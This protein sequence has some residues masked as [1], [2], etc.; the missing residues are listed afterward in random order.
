MAS[1]YYKKFHE[2]CIS[3]LG[4]KCVL[5]SSL[6][7]LQIDH[8]NPLSKSFDL[9]Q[10]WTSYGSL[11]FEEELVK[12]QVLCKPCHQVK[13]G[14]EASLR[15]KKDRNECHGSLSQY[16]R[17]GCRCDKCKLC[18]KVWKRSRSG[19]TVWKERA[20]TALCG[21]D[22]RYT[23]HGCRCDLCRRAH[24]QAAKDYRQKKLDRYQSLA[25]VVK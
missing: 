7:A 19:K 23:R 14:L 15:N 5:C 13:S 9:S 20:E 1:Y 6:D 24:A 2:E 12:C 8:I 22:S 25:K 10:N 4:G 16:V 11:I 18:H 17:Y 3:R 21:T